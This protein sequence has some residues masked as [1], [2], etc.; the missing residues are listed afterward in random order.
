MHT[1][2]EFR[3][4]LS[5]QVAVRHSS[6]TIK[7]TNLPSVFVNRNPRNLERMRIGYRPDGYH[8]EKPLKYNYWHKLFLSISTRHV[9][10]SINHFENGEVLKASTKEW[11]IKKYLYKGND[12]AAYINLGRVLGMRC[13]QS[14]LTEISCDIEQLNPEGKIALFL[15]AVQDSGV[16]LKEPPQYKKPY[17]WDQHRPEKPWEIVE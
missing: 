15:K 16:Q 1:I 5:P 11:C 9:T 3:K 14:G 6:N 8:V 17:P 10:A 13:L 4:L 7:N 2:K 12:T